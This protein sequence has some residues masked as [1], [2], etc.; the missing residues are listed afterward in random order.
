LPSREIVE[1]DVSFVSSSRW[2]AAPPPVEGEFLSVVPDLVMEILS[3]ANASRDRGE[4]RAIYERNGV[5]EYWLVD[6][7]ARRV[8]ILARVGERFEDHRVV[9]V[10]GVAE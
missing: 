2:K 10:D 5:L 3:P 9:D 1:P 7:R 8:T 6:P 4:K